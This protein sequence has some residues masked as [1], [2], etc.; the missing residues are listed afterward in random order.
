MRSVQVTRSS[1]PA[2]QELPS[3]KTR[4]AVKVEEVCVHAL[5]QPI[6]RAVGSGTVSLSQVAQRKVFHD[7]GIL[8]QLLGSQSWWTAVWYSSLAMAPVILLFFWFVTSVDFNTVQVTNMA[9]L[10]SFV[11]EDCHKSYFTLRGKLS[12]DGSTQGGRLGG[13]YR[14]VIAILDVSYVH[15]N[16]DVSCAHCNHDWSEPQESPISKYL[17]VIPTCS[18]L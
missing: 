8:I 15:C 2:V 16:H 18:V 9:Q 11:S 13:C 5:S 10:H 1:W 6:R 4:T 12:S 14:N 7:R 17:T 3:N